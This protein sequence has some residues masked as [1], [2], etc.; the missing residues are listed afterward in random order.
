MEDVPAA[1]TWLE[2][3]RRRSGIRKAEKVAD[4]E[5]KEGLVGICILSDGLG[6]GPEPSGTTPA[7]QG[8]LVELNCETDFVARNEVFTA[9]VRDLSHT[10]AMFPGLAGGMAV[11]DS[12]RLVDLP[13]DEFMQFPIMSS[14]PETP[15]ASAPRSVQTAILDV[16]SRLGEKIS[17][18]RV[19][20][21]SRARR[22]AADAPKRTTQPGARS[23]LSAFAH[24]A[25]VAPSATSPAAS[26]QP[27]YLMSAGRVVSLLL[28]RF[29]GTPPTRSVESDK[30]VRALT[31]SLARQ[32]AGME[33]RSIQRTNADA[34]SDTALYS[35]NFMMLLP[36]AGVSPCADGEESVESVLERWA[37][38]HLAVAKK[39]DGRAVEVYDMRRWKV[40]ETA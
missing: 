13:L 29:S 16:V 18:T 1:L 32:T 34:E 15:S 22:P 35:Q 5:A 14:S 23:I 17:M 3:D 26:R 31:R 8:G 28:T 21:V 36:T 2:D 39:D 40:G 27:D 33:T 6:D 12:P 9:L 10:A 7:P 11:D 20:A 4:R 19:S 38:E 30:M 24:G 37:K 25:V